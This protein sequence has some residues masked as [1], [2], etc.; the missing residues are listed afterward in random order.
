MPASA[1]ASELAALPP[2][3]DLNRRAPLHRTG[4]RAP[5]GPLVLFAHFLPPGPPRP[6][7]APAV[8]AELRLAAQLFERALDTAVTP[9]GSTATRPPHRQMPVV[10]PVGLLVAL[11]TQAAQTGLLPSRRP[12]S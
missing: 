4:S 2:T 1:A 6:A 8:L 7:C 5:F 11:P 12:L 9:P 3:A 10:L